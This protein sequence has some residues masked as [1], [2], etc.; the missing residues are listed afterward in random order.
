MDQLQPLTALAKAKLMRDLDQH[1]GYS[2][3]EIISLNPTEYGGN[4]RKASCNY[5][6]Y[7]ECLMD[8]H[9]C[10]YSRL[11]IDSSRLLHNHAAQAGAGAQQGNP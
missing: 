10:K 9:P 8:K 6:H 2:H 11:R 7:L 3:Y 4:F 5:L 1:P